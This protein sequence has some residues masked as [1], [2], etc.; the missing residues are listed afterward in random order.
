MEKI[1]RDLNVY[2]EI[3]NKNINESDCVIP[4]LETNGANVWDYKIDS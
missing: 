3:F 2:V 1:F 4:I